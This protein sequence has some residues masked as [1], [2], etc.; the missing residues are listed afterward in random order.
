MR[1]AILHFLYKKLFSNFGMF[2]EYPLE[3]HRTKSMPIIEQLLKI[4]GM[5]IDRPTNVCD[6]GPCFRYI[7]TA[8]KRL[9]SSPREHIAIS[10]SLQDDGD[11]DN[12]YM[13]IEIHR[14]Q[15]HNKDLRDG[16]ISVSVTHIYP[17]QIP[18]LLKIIDQVINHPI[19]P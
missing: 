19:Q 1:Q 6:G 4:D 9:N 17:N 18:N 7:Q 5:E 12:P 14:Y 2:P 16:I 13:V 15:H 10:W 3:M 11:M 8:M